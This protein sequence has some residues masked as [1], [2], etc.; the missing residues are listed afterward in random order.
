MKNKNNSGEIIIYRT[1]DDEVK[2]DVR[3]EDDTV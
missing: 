2:I 1:E 3:L